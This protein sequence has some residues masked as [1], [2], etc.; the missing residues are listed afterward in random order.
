MSLIEVSYYEINPTKSTGRGL[1]KQPVSV[2]VPT[3][4]RRVHVAVTT[5]NFSFG[6]CA[7]P[8]PAPLSQ[9]A[10][11]ITNRD[12]AD[13]AKGEYRF[14]FHA[15]LRTKDPDAEWCGYFVLEILCFG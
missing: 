13:L 7:T 5:M 3:T 4:T 8:S 14:E 2:V 1:M 10:Y 6:S 9:I 11:E 15:I 12:D